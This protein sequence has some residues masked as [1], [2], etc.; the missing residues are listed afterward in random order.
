MMIDPVPYPE[1]VVMET[2]LRCNLRCRMCFNHDRDASTGASMAWELY[3]SVAQELFPYVQQLELSVAGEPMLSSHFREEVELAKQYSIR[4]L[5]TT[6]ATRLKDDAILDLVAR[7]IDWLKISF[8]AATKETYEAIR[9]GANFDEVTASLRKL[10]ALREKTGKPARL[11]FSCVVMKR[12]LRELPDWVELV[13]SLGA[14]WLSIVPMTTHPTHSAEMLGETLKH[15]PDLARHFLALALD[16][17]RAL[18][19]PVYEKISDY[20]NKNVSMASAPLSVPS[21]SGKRETLSFAT[22]PRPV[23]HCAFLYD[24][25]WI[26]REGLVMTCCDIN[27]QVAGDLRKDSFSKIWNNKFLQNLRQKIREGNPP[28]GCR[29]CLILQVLRQPFV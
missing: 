13:H 18:E 27:Q 10:K 3:Q 14:T 23:M 12:N 21:S 19:F 5:A 20:L 16:K 28:P 22:D 7:K 2:T 6:N 15:C 24:Q 26:S 17:A 8:D 9:I 4:I 25:T 29:N 11:E 1:S